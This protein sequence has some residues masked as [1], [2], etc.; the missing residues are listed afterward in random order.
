MATIAFESKTSE[1]LE[2]SCG[3]NVMQ[4]G[5]E[6]IGDACENPHYKCGGCGAYACVDYDLRIVNNIDQAQAGDWR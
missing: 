2:C 3:N 5:F 1:F 6:D 4:D